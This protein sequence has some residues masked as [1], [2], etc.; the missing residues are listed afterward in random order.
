[1]TGVGR[2][3]LNFDGKKGGVRRKKRNKRCVTVRGDTYMTLPG[4]KSTFRKQE[5]SPPPKRTE[6]KKVTIRGR[7]WARGQRTT[8]SGVGVGG[9]PQKTATP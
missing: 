1:V 6:I 4:E 3:D 7:M 5:R 8:S 9:D 2:V